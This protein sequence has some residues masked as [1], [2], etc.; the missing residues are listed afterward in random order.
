MKRSMFK[1]SLTLG[2]IAGILSINFSLSAFADNKA[3]IPTG[4]ETST[5]HSGQAS[6]QN[7]SSAAAQNHSKAIVEVGRSTTVNKTLVSSTKH[8]ARRHHSSGTS[9]S[10]MV[11]TIQQAARS[12]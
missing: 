5:K 1:S 2:V 8:A 12:K 4:V 11:N 6:R 3:S 9:H 10:Y 7:S